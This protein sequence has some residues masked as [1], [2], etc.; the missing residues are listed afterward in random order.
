RGVARSFQQIE[1]LARAAHR[2]V[3]IGVPHAVPRLVGDMA[4]V[5]PLADARIV[6]QHIQPAM[7]FADRLHQ[8]FDLSG[9]G[10]IDLGEDAAP[11]ALTMAS[12]TSF[13]ASPSRSATTTKAPSRA[14]VSAM[15]RPIPAPP[16]V[17]R[18]IL[19]SSRRIRSR[20]R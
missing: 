13:A 20:P 1:G 10:D 16:P 11:F 2:A 12:P 19:S 18:A 7:R 5:R 8:R 3:E 15:A 17:T 14:N 4:E 9:V 6:D